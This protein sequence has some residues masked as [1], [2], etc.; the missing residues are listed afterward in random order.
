[1]EAIFLLAAIILLLFAG[2]IAFGAPYVPTLSRQVESALTILDLKPGQTMLEL[3]CGDGRLLKAAAR[4]G[5]Y[6]VGYELNP[7]LF[8]YAKLATWHYRNYARVVWGNYWTADWP[9]ADGMYAFLL[10]PYMSKLHNKVVQYTDKR[11][12]RVVSYAFQI[13]EKKPA[14]EK[15]G[16][17]LYEY[18]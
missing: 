15:D 13:Q 11:P 5:I 7:L 14:A 9:K 18:N 2:V 8:I 10:K 4:R 1:L 3:G 6:A 17:F 16:M 12:F